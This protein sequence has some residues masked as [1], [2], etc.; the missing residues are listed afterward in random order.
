MLL[1]LGK[2]EALVQALCGEAAAAAAAAGARQCPEEQ[3]PSR[4][5]GRYKRSISISVKK[6]RTT[7]RS[8]LAGFITGRDLR[9][10]LWN[11]ALDAA[12]V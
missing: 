11:K 1:L 3:T 4:R 8:F 5:A 12:V 10:A 6:K 9:E 2:W 7:F